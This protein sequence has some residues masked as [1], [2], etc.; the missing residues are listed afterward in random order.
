MECAFDLKP[1]FE[2]DII[3]V[4]SDLLPEGFVGSPE[5]CCDA[6]RKMG[7]II[8]RIGLLSAQAQGLHTSVTSVRQMNVNQTIYLMAGKAKE[9][10]KLVV[11]GLL[12]MGPKD[13]YLFDERG[14]LRSR[15][16]TPAV[17]DFFV[18]SAYQRRGLGKRL[19]DNMLRDLNLTL[20]KCAVDRPSAMMTAFLAKHY[21]LVRTIAQANN[22]VLYDGFFGNSDGDADADAN[23]NA[24]DSI[25][26]N[27]NTNTNNNTNTNTKF[28]R[29][30]RA[31]AKPEMEHK[32]LSMAEIMEAGNRHS[33]DSRTIIKRNGDSRSWK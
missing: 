17:L 18:H 22:Y 7:S 4:R 31:A 6:K 32:V 2:K 26:T 16:G 20:C 12:K 8:D 24:K 27:T 11:T 25:R 30:P 10:A 19:F 21:G 14:Q 29:R 1:L 15:I 33:R 28:V 23:A 13:L 5:A 9:G 3:K